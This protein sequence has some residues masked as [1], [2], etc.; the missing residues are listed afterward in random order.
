MLAGL[1]R[2]PLSRPHY[3]LLLMGG[4]GQMAPPGNRCRGARSTAKG[5]ADT[6]RFAFTL[7]PGQRNIPAPICKA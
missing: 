5:S 4:L 6:R 7:T 1:D 2:L 3:V